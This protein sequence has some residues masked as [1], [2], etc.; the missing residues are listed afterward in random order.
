MLCSINLAL[1]IKLFL[2][3]QTPENIVLASDSKEGEEEVQESGVVRDVEEVE[4]SEVGR[5]PLKVK[6][7]KRQKKMSRILLKNKWT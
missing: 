1:A 7:T 2:R 6:E 5:K 4:E 3:G